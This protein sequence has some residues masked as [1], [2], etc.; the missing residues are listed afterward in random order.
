[1]LELTFFDGENE[2]EVIS[3]SQ[4]C[5]KRLSEI[6]FAKNVEYKDITLTIEEEDYNICAVK[7]TKKNRKVL[8]DLIECERH[9]ELEKVFDNMDDNPTIKEMRESMFYIKEL[10][11]VYKHLKVESNRYFS[12]E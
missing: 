5:Y 12:Y 4:H 2:P 1:M 6:G 11:K 3:V 7:L 9:K 10:T 8:L